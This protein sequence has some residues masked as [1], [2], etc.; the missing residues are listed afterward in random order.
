MWCGLNKNNFDMLG[1]LAGLVSVKI[2][3]QDVSIIRSP[4]PK[5]LENTVADM[6]VQSSF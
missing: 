6:E 5:T 1:V 2:F 4:K 3:P